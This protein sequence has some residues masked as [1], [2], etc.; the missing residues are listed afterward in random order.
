MRCSECGGKIYVYEPVYLRYRVK[1]NGVINWSS[2]EISEDYLSDMILAECNNCGT[3]YE[4]SK[5]RKHVE[6]K[7]KQE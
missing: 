6:K 7:K 2:P 3:R 5:N 1:E 4:I